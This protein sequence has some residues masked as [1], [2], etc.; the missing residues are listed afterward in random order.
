MLS[1]KVLAMTLS[2][3]ALLLHINCNYD[4][5]VDRFDFLNLNFSTIST[6]SLADASSTNIMRLPLHMSMACQK[7]R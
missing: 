6:Q 4:K 5:F 3:F 2:P 1:E 7:E